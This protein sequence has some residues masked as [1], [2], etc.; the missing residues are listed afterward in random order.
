MAAQLYQKVHCFAIDRAIQAYQPS[1]Q[2]SR[3]PA[4][5]VFRLQ[6]PGVGVGADACL[7]V[8]YLQVG[9]TVMV[10][11]TVRLVREKSEKGKYAVQYLR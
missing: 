1:S 10:W 8:C 9:D 4:R 5:P 3:P 11:D 2:V 6:P 7:T